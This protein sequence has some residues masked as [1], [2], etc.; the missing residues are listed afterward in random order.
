MANKEQ[1]LSLRAEQPDLT[2]AQIAERLGCMP[3][4]VRA[5]LSRERLSKTRVRKKP[6]RKPGS[7]SSWT[8]AQLEEMIF[9]R[10]VEKKRWCVIAREL[11]RPVATCTYQFRQYEDSRPKRNVEPRRIAPE[12]VLSDAARRNK[13]PRTITAALFGDPAPGQSALDKKRG[14][15]A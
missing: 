3:E 12:H 2:S 5:T 10:E 15:Y 7:N 8:E 4:Y 14:V 13:A 9:K 6:G 11:G 1:V